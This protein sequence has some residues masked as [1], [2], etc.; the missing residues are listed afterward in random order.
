[1]SH[2]SP[3][4]LFHVLKTVPV[5]RT[6]TISPDSLRGS[7]CR[8]KES[9]AVAIQK[10]KSRRPW[11]TI[12]RRRPRKLSK[13]TCAPIGIPLPKLLRRCRNCFVLLTLS[14]VGTQR[15]QKNND[16]FGRRFTEMNADLIRVQLR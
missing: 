16:N 5:N 15:V 6:Q 1:M 3:P 8:W 12:H 14:S 10:L 11:F 7:T 13:L 2:H 4:Q 9:S